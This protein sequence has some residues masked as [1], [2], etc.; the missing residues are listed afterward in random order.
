MNLIWI[1]NDIKE[2]LLIVLGVIMLLWLRKKMYL[3]LRDLLKYL[4]VK[5]YKI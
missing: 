3:F 4:E 1:L 2:F 5:C